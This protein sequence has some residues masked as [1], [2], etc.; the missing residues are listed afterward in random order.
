MERTK[1]IFSRPLH[2]P[3]HCAL[4][5]LPHHR[6]LPSP[7]PSARLPYRHRPALA[8]QD[9]GEEAAH[10]IEAS[11]PA[12][13]PEPSEEEPT[14]RIAHFAPVPWVD[15]GTARVGKAVERTLAVHNPSSTEQMISARGFASLC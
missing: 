11:N 13:D 8:A 15:F 9:V 4:V 12:Q 3:S 5:L 14:L 6:E 1:R 10:V 7:T 2:R